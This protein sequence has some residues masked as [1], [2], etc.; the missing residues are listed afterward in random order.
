MILT[1]LTFGAASAMA[2]QGGHCSPEGTWYGYNDNGY[3]WIVTISRSGPQSFTTVMDWGANLDES[4]VAQ[5]TDWRGEMVKK[6]RHHGYDWT[7]MALL[8][9][10]E[11]GP[12][13]F[14]LGYC[15]LTA[16]FTGCDSWE[17]EG[18]CSYY[19]FFS[20]EQDPFEDGVLVD[21][22]PVHA[23]FKRMPMSYPE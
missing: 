6:S 1:V 15:P 18:T 19:A 3:V 11:G 10:E 17:G 7:T 14:A 8:R 21:G 5:S 12:I 13:P 16:Q 22:G 4:P 9:G 23:F 20:P 2:G